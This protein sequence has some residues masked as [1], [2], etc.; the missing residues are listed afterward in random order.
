MTNLIANYTILDFILIRINGSWIPLL[1]YS[2]YTFRKMFRNILFYYTSNTKRKKIDNATLPCRILNGKASPCQFP[3]SLKGG[4]SNLWMYAIIIAVY[5]KTHIISCTLSVAY[6]VSGI[7]QQIINGHSKNK[8]SPRE[9]KS[10]CRQ[11]VH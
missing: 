7:L 5:H 10:I 1:W 9:V 11:I 6:L 8:T 2:A 4:W 3:Y